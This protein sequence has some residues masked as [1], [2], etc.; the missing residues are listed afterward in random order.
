MVQAW[1]VRAGRGGERADAAL[2]EGL[3]IAGWSEVGD[4]SQVPNRDQMRRVVAE[5]Y[6][7]LSAQVI[8]NWT[9]QLWRFREEIALGDL[10]ITPVGGRRLAAGRVASPYQYRPDANPALR[11]VRRIHW[12][13][14][15]ID[16]DTVQPDLRDSL[17]SLLTVF[18]LSRNEAAERMVSV[19][20]HGVD[21]GA[22]DA[23]LIATKLASPERLEEFVRES[24]AEGRPVSLTIRNLL[25]IWGHSH[26]RLSVVDEIRASLDALGLSTNPPFSEGSINSTVNV[27]PVGVEPDAGIHVPTAQ[28]LPPATNTD[29]QPVTFRIRQLPSADIASSL[30]WVGPDDDLRRATTLMGLN[31]FSQLPILDADRR[32]RGAVSWETIGMA[33]LSNPAPT[34]TDATTRQVREVD[35]EEDLLEWIPEIYRLGSIFV[36]DAERRIIGIVTTADLTSQLGSQLRP[37]LLI[38]EIERRL[39]RIIDRALRHQRITLDQIRNQLRGNRRTRVHEAR[40]LTLGEYPWILES[41][42]TWDQLGWG[43]DQ[44]LFVDRLRVAASFRNDLMHLNPDLDAEAEDELLPLRGLLTMLRALDPEA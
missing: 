33:Y 35:G 15:D 23:S 28:E 24:V 13:R 32:L 17:G 22:S 31:N 5:T 43:I 25:A 2:R 42:A 12:I 38:A 6:P 8:G 11:H 21:P 29:D 18:E 34:L 20:E 26:R 40:H 1:V 3:A 7:E 9:G 37:F 36:R 30:T 4:L 19:A 14:T 16:R 10:V 41:R 44:N 39:R 27:V